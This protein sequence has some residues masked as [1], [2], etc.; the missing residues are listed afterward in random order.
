MEAARAKRK[1]WTVATF[2]GNHTHTQA[3][4]V[5]FEL[6]TVFCHERLPADVVVEAWEAVLSILCSEY[7]QGFSGGVYI[8]N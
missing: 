8:W 4:E 7:E 5:I 2:A 6:L 3:S 1:I